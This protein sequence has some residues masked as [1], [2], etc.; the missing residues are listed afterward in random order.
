MYKKFL[1]GCLFLISFTTTGHAALIEVLD[2]GNGFYRILSDGQPYGGAVE[3]QLS[4]SAVDRI[5]KVLDNGTNQINRTPIPNTNPGGGFGGGGAG[6]K[7]TTSAGAT[8]NGALVPKS[9]TTTAVTKYEPNVTKTG[10]TTAGGTTAPK[11]AGSAGNPGGTTAPKQIGTASPKQLG[12]GTGGTGGGVETPPKTTPTSSPKT[13][14][15]NV[16]GNGLAI[17]GGVVGAIDFADAEKPKDRKTNWG[18]IARSAGDGAAMAAGTAA[19]INLIPG[20]GQ[21]GYGAAIAIGAVGG[22]IAAGRKAFSETDCEYDPLIGVYS[23]CHT[24]RAMSNIQARN[25][26]IGGEM[27]CDSF[28][29]I[30][31]CVQGRKEHETDQGFRGLFMNDHWSKECRIKYCPGYGEPI[32]SN[33]MYSITPAAKYTDDG[34]ACWYW[35]C[36]EGMTRD[37]AKC[38]TDVT[39]P[40]QDTNT[41]PPPADAPDDAKGCKTD[42]DCVG[43]KLPQYAT[44][45]RCIQKNKNE[46]VCA[47]TECKPGTYLVKKNGRSMGWCRAGTEPNENQ[48]NTVPPQQNQ[49]DTDE[50]TLPTPVKC[51]DPDNMDSNCNCVVPGTV[52]R[53]GKCVCRDDNQEIKNGKCEWTAKYVAGLE[54]DL[55]SKFNN[56]TATI[57]GFEKN[58]W[59][60]ENGEFNTARLAS[61]SIAGIVLGTVGG[62]VT[63]NLVK[64]AQVKKGFE[65]IGCYVGGQSVA[66][67]GDEFNVGR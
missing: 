11:Q 26:D 54:S 49:L 8:N 36:P 31:K 35:L 17:L 40:S 6:G 60:D 59:R 33:G 28:P 63:A 46:R 45:G 7:G 43:A 65:D 24:S 3:S 10:T 62:I 64:K 38:V 18:D 47:A 20:L 56:L 41:T 16:V 48:N 52:E 42:A 22:A 51:S 29:Y 58:V 44:A 23:C 39:S 13:T 30:T 2:L 21:I 15:G 1:F 55:D 57:G 27:F 12:P 19:A 4:K 32:D 14:G 66:G 25:V 37:G 9:N 34:G 5:L 61:D 67:F 50:I 53:G